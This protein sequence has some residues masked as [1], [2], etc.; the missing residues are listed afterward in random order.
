M[1]IIPQNEHNH[2]G[3]EGLL[4]NFFI[5]FYQTG[6]GTEWIDYDL[7]PPGVLKHVRNGIFIGWALDGYFG[8]NKGQT[9]LNDI[10]A[11]YL[12]TFKDNKAQRLPY[13][14]QKDLL[15][16]KTHLDYTKHK[17]REFQGLK[18]IARASKIVSQ[19]RNSDSKQDHVFYAIK[20]FCEDLIFS[21]GIPT[22]SQLLEFAEQN[23]K[24]KE[25]STL[26]AKCRS[27][28]NW[29]EERDFTI[30]KK[31]K[32][33]NLNNYWEITQMTRKE[34]LK[35]INNKRNETSKAKV[36][37]AITE[38]QHLNKKITGNAIARITGQN[39]K[40]ARKYLKEI[41]NIGDQK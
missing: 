10:I 23:F 9:Y 1:N 20:F 21:Q 14:P 13:K 16:S 18:S 31:K 19:Q 33:E 32:Y 34:N 12:I 39:V 6:N 17:L 30:L 22:Y 35:E 26:R 41:Q 24:Y 11:R 40:T 36:L 37:G 15:D 3:L 5:Y 4:K 27:I 29:Y 28:Y 25:S 38:L 8:T 2:H 7:P